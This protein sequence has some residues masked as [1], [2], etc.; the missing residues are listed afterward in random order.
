MENISKSLLEITNK[1]NDIEFSSV[2]NLKQIL[3]NTSEIKKIVDELKIENE[4]I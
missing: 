4:R 3:K 2:D 1:I